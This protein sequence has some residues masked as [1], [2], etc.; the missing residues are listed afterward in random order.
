MSERQFEIVLYGAS[1]FTGQLVAEYL[2]QHHPDLKWAIAG[3]NG[4]KLEALRNTLGQPALPIL[5]ADSDDGPALTAMVQQARVVITTVGPY[6]RHGS[7]LLEACARE[8]THYC[9]L[10]GEAQWLAEV[11]ERVDPIARASHWASPVRSQ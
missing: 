10:T 6:A 9:D 4:G 1:G 2:A 8:G 3:R 5:I 7:P 11:Y